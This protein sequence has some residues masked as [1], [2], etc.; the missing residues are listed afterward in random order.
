MNLDAL[1]VHFHVLAPD[2]LGYGRTS[3][4][5]DF[6]NMWDA[7][8]R[9]IERFLQALCVGPAA[10]VGNSM[11]GSMLCAVAAMDRPRWEGM[12]RIVIVSGGGHAP[13]NAARKTLT[14]YGGTIDEMRAIVNTMFFNPRVAKDERYIAKRHRLSLEP[15]AWEC[16]AAARFR[17]PGRVPEGLN[18]AVDYRKI[19]VPTLI[20][21]GAHD[22]LR[23]PGSVLQVLPNSGHFPQIDEAEMFN[24]VVINFL[25]TDSRV[26]RNPG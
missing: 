16:T 5:F 26:A 25:K 9:Q 23:E 4:I 20:V 6:E 2:W 19:N 11:G 21:A 3:K 22:N 15:G 14:S 7:R 18:R 17:V 13:E 12:T 8:V 10:F 24:Q 1:A